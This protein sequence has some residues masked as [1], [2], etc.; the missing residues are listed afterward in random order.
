M[1][2]LFYMSPFFY[3][4]YPGAFDVQTDYPFAPF[5]AVFPDSIDT[6][7]KYLVRVG[8]NGR[9]KIRCAPQLTIIT[10][11]FQRSCGRFNSKEGTIGS[12]DLQIYKG[13]SQKSA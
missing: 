11:L 10:Q 6:L 4:I 9:L 1:N 5:F 13:G 12:I 7:K 2:E 3:F 8:S